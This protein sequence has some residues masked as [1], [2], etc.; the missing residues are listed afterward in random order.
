MPY[1]LDTIK[2]TLQREYGIRIGKPALKL[3]LE[4]PMFVPDVGRMIAVSNNIANLPTS[5][6]Y[7]VFKG[8]VGDEYELE[9]NR[10]SLFKHAR[11]LTPAEIAKCF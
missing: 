4:V 5:T 1:N 11:L 8:M 9:G 7:G 2:A 3:L 6:R 10:T